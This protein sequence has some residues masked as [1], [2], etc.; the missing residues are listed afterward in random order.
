MTSAHGRASL[1]I[2]LVSFAS[3]C[4][5]L[6]DFLNLSLHHCAVVSLKVLVSYQ[7]HFEHN[8]TRD[9]KLR[10]VFYGHV[11]P[12]QEDS[13]QERI[14][15]VRLGDYQTPRELITNAKFSIPKEDRLGKPQSFVFEY[16]SLCL[17]HLDLTSKEDNMKVDFLKHD[18]DFCQERIFKDSI[19]GL[20]LGFVQEDTPVNEVPIVP[21]IYGSQL[22]NTDTQYPKGDARFPSWVRSMDT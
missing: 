7:N 19:I 10:H 5:D 21:N 14:D 6:I 20:C 18:G 22:A 9:S 17:A 15:A 11:P 16:I 2:I 12:Y 3:E 8:G 13:N 4:K 1:M